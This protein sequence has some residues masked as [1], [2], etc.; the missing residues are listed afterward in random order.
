MPDIGA[1]LFAGVMY[2][3]RMAVLVEIHN[4]GSDPGQRT[5][6]VAHIEHAL[7]DSP[8]DWKVSI[9][10]SQASDRWELKILGPNGFERT[11]M[12]EGTA[13]ETEPLAIGRI[14]AKMVPKSS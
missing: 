3:C 11:Y 7:A 14:V 8:G 9:L 13:G 12:L 1:T 10:G 2:F 5:E 6:I 4:T